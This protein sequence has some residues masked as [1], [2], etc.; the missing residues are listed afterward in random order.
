MKI[1]QEEIDKLKQQLED[2][3]MEHFNR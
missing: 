3:K 1:K 2:T